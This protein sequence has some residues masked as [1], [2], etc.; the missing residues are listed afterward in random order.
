MPDDITVIPENSGIGTS[1]HIDTLWTIPATVIISNPIFCNYTLI[2]TLS[3]IP[4][5]GI[6]SCY[7]IS[8]ANQE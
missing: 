7:N 8:I 4:E 6:T 1:I 2:Y 3:A 5:A